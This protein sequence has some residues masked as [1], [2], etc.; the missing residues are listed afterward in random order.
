MLT[1]QD[2]LE[3]YKQGP[4]AMA[5]LIE[6]LIQANQKL[7]QRVQELE[8][9]LNKNSQNSHKPPSSDGFKKRPKKPKRVRGRERRK[10][11]GQ[12][13]HPGTTLKMSDEVDHVIRHEVKVCRGCGQDLSDLS[14][15]VGQRR[16]I[17]DIP[18]P[19]LI[20]TEHQAIV[21]ECPCC[22]A[23]NAGQF[24]SDLRGHVQYGSRL[25][26][27][28]IYLMI[29]QL[30]PYERT[31]ELLKTLYTLSPST[32]TLHRMIRDGY[33]R[34]EEAEKALKG[35]MVNAD[36]IHCDETGHRV[37]S[38][39][40][41]LHVASTKLMTFYYS[42]KARGQLAHQ[43]GGIL[44][45]YK[46]IAIHDFYR[47]YLKVE[48]EHGLCNAHLIRELKAVFE[49]DGAQLWAKALIRLLTTANRLVG[50]A[51]ESRKDR[52]SPAAYDRLMTMYDALWAKAD[53]LNPKATANGKRGRTK[54][55]KTRNLIDRLITYKLD[56]LRFI[57]DFKVP[58]DNNVAERDLRMVKV[59][60][61]IS[62]CFRS[63]LGAEMFC[64]IRGYIS[65]LLKQNYEIFPILTDA[66]QGKV[67]IPIPAE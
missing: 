5:D 55:T 14:G 18:Q 46:G 24:P 62:N 12:S 9:R 21:K 43:A 29:Y 32:G 27:L 49:R 44:P 25:R 59:Q 20:R 36:V 34:L 65:T 50:A 40:R 61:K 16:Q 2:I 4:E 60:Q 15:A 3:L 11:G 38:K 30:V 13:D 66:M 19:Q 58:F 42:N 54:Q 7:S 33:Q 1:R 6:Q 22:G 41:W 23:S 35:A 63:Q 26:A 48:C 57:Y 51:R 67:F 8:D 47:S 53:Q 31:Q 56:I 52:L 45:A 10:P 37:G 64:R 39:T 17:I 28:V